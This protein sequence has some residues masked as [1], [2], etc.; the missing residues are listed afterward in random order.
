MNGSSR[1]LA[2]LGLMVVLPL[3]GTAVAQERIDIS[4]WGTGNVQPVPVD[5]G[6]PWGW[7]VRDFMEDPDRELYNHAKAKLLRGEQIYSHSIS[8]FDIERYCREAPHFDYTWF[9]MQHSVMTYAEVAA[10]FAACPGVGAAPILRL[11]DALEGS[12]QKAMD[13][14]MLGI[15][16]PT[17]DDAIVAR[18]SARYAR[19]PPIARR[20][21]G[22]G[23]GPGLWASAVPEG[24]TFFNSVNDNMLVIVMIETVEAVNN[25]LEIATVPG[26]DVV[27]IGNAD[28]A[29]FS[30]LAQN[31]PEYRDL[32]IKVRNAAYRAGKFFGNAQAT[33]G[34]QS[35]PL[36]MESRV[37][38][39][40][41]SNDG[42]TYP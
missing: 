12:V 31:T 36:Q 35:N 32:Q 4:G 8:S 27:L 37:H 29:N 2:T 42:W 3:V 6:R 23:Q 18:E 11:P 16:V 25:A 13:M 40:G 1:F 19:F 21:A 28:L 39:M 41:P 20:S 34:T 22:G 26:V 30:G 17:V 5:P 14:G 15:V 9:E 10:M 7:A 33:N 24:S 38:L